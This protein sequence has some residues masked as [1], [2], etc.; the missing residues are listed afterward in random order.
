M[1]R[2]ND[3]DLTPDEAVAK[4]LCPETGR[5]LATVNPEE[6]VNALWPH[7]MSEEAARRRKLIMD[8]H[9][10]HPKPAPAKD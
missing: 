3:Q 1:P 4:D 6:W 2:V 10:A 7:G 5:L 9:A 8:W